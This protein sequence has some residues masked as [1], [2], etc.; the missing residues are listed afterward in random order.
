MEKKQSTIESLLMSVWHANIK[1][2]V[3]SVSVSFVV[4]VVVVVG[5][6]Y[7]YLFSTPTCSMAHHC[8]YLVSLHPMAQATRA[9]IRTAT[10]VFG[11]A[12]TK[13]I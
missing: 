9:T 12:T 13:E 1:P 7:S 11:D 5:F 3:E 6:F 8:L 4:V 2:Q 10:L